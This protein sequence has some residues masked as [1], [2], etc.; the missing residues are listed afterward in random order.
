MFFF[1]VERGV[2][3]NSC[4]LRS[5]WSVFPRTHLYRLLCPLRFT[6]LLGAFSLEDYLL[7]R[8]RFSLLDC[9]NI[10]NYHSVEKG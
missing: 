10:R 7:V 1:F 3:I 8:T 4:F 5:W 6:V 9:F 2:I